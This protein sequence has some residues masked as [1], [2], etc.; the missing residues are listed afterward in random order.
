MPPLAKC[1]LTALRE[2]RSEG[3]TK[4]GPAMPALPGAKY[5][6]LPR[7]SPNG[8]SRWI[9]AGV[10][11]AAGPM[12]SDGPEVRHGPRYGVHCTL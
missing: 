5:V 11:S 12:L 6:P 10:E 1:P 4:D 7:A 9:G 3:Y 2:R 8:I